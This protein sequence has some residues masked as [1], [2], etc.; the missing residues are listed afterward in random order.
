MNLKRL[1]AKYARQLMR[2]KNENRR[3]ILYGLILLLND[4]LLSRTRSV[5]MKGLERS[6]GEAVTNAE[7]KSLP[8]L[9]QVKQISLF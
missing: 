4:Q 5:T 1:R 3:L 9:K 8:S 7:I 6:P 2:T